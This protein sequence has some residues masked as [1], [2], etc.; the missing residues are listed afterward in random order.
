M[1]SDK[2]IRIELLEHRDELEIVLADAIRPELDAAGMDR[3]RIVYG[4]EIG[5]GVD[6][7]F[8]GITS[9]DLG[10]I[11]NGQVSQQ[12]PTVI[13]CDELIRSW[14]ASS[15]VMKQSLEAIAI[16]ELVHRIDMGL[17][18]EIGSLES[19]NKV[20]IET[21]AE[22]AVDA[23]RADAAAGDASE[24]K[25]GIQVV[26][27]G[28]EFGRLLLHL[29][30][31]M[32]RNGRRFNFNALH[33]W[34]HYGNIPMSA[35]LNWVH[36]EVVAHENDPLSTI[37]ELPMCPVFSRLWQAG[38]YTPEF[39][40][41]WPASFRKIWEN[42]DPFNNNVSDLRLPIPSETASTA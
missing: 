21:W 24:F 6:A 34:R 30:I 39:G 35:C 10:V 7:P 20:T 28:P 12:I 23:H 11:V 41:L 2:Y 37:K 38:I 36:D 4:S 18:D 31:R 14:N 8:G 3:I 17:V 22:Q 32:H 25:G 5:I 1:N 19:V 16:H 29:A 42:F 9:G 33:G 15:E 40:H 26:H 27:H 13:V